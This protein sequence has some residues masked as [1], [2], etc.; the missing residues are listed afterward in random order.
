MLATNDGFIEALIEDSRYQI[1]ADG[2]IWSTVCTTGKNSKALDWRKLPFRKS[3]SGHLSIKYCRKHLSVHRII[4]RRFHGPLQVELAVNHIDGNKENNTPRNLELITH[5]ENMLHCF[6]VLG[7]IPL[8][9]RSKI[10]FEI[11]ETIRVDHSKGLT[12]SELRA[13]YR[14]SKS[15][16]SFIVNRKTWKLQNQP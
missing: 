2:T 8:K 11:A 4:Y 14:L 7:H 13:K 3:T 6:R 15:S 12:N 5:S 1:R 10:T 9:P 16:I